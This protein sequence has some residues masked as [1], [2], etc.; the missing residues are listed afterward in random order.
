MTAAAAAA[1]AGQ[2]CS[3][4]LTDFSFNGAKR[5]LRKKRRE[6]TTTTTTTTMRNVYKSDER[7]PLNTRSL[8]VTH[9]K[10]IRL[11]TLHT[12]PSYLLSPTL[13]TCDIYFFL[14]ESITMIM[15]NDFGFYSLFFG[16]LWHMAISLLSRLFT[17]FCI[18]TAA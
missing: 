17:L 3:K 9:D 10:Y 12:P 1:A 14:N 2:E 7:A 16:L 4:Q 11:S 6:T 18:I 8:A 15:I 5:E 13:F